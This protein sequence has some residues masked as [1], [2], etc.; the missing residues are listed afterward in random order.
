MPRYAYATHTRTWRSRR[1]EPRPVVLLE[2]LWALRWSWLRR[3]C[4]YAI[5]CEAAEAL[6][7]ARRLARD[8][9]ERGQSAAAVRRQWEKEVLPM[10]VRHVAPQLRWADR[11]ITSPVTDQ[12]WREL[13]ACLNRL[14]FPVAAGG[15]TVSGELFGV[16]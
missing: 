11:V 3:Q 4:A 5:Y 1:W 10:H 12:A 16:R 2:G 6:R 14:G 15:R 9:R 13:V 7:L 8:V